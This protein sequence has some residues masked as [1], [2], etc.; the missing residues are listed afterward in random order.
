VLAA[1]SV[2]ATLA[3]GTALAA[4]PQ[5]VQGSSL[6]GNGLKFLGTQNVRQ[7]AAREQRA[8][9][10]SDTRAAG[11]YNVRPVLSPKRANTTG[12]P[13]G[14]VANPRGL[15]I[16]PSNVSSYDGLSAADERLA[17]D[18]NNYTYVPPDGGI[19]RGGDGVSAQAVNGAFGFFGANMILFSA[20]VTQNEFFGLPPAIIRTD[21]PTF[22]GPSLGDA[23]CLYDPG[24]Q[25]MILLSWGTGQDPATG[26]FTGTNDY[27]IAVSV[28]SDVLGSYYLYDLSLDPPGS[29]GCHPACLSDHPTLSSDAYVVETSYNKYNAVSGAF[30]GGRLV[31]MSKAD[32]TAGA[33]TTAYIFNAGRAGGGRLYTLQGANAPADGT[34]DFSQGGTLW[35]LSALQFVSGVADNRIAIEALRNTSQIDFDPGLIT[36]DRSIVTGVN[37]YQNPPVTPQK[38]GEH[39]LGNSLGEPLNYLDSGSDEM[40][41]TWYAGGQLW[42]ILDSKVGGVNTARSGLLWMTVTPGAGPNVTGTLTHQQFVTV[43]ADWLDY[44]GIAVSGDGSNAIVASSLAGPNEYPSGVYGRLD[45]GTWK[46]DAVAVYLDGVRPVDDFDC[47]PEFNPDFARGCRFGDYNAAVVGPADNT[48]ILETEYMTAKARVSFANWGTALAVIDF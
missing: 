12:L 27:F 20:P 26:G 8:P 14:R 22:P 13:S 7:L 32:L 25:R 41:P 46:V 2:V 6:H 16:V 10:S 11:G 43:P 42:G 44:G 37:H 34:Y 38:D 47:Y 39:P 28:T 23:K 29:N 19:C 21:P 3:G 5:K 9:A 30:E 31:V 48:F 17:N 35:F 1:T 24:T 18:G 4:T 33:S 45:T 15:P 36:Y 40:Q